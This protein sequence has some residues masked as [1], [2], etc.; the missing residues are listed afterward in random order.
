M[1][2]K[3]TKKYFSLTLVF[4]F[5]LVTLA[6]C[7]SPG[8]SG[9]PPGGSGAPAGGSG[10]TADDSDDTPAA[11]VLRHNLAHIFQ[12]DS[13]Q[14]RGALFFA[15]TL[16]ERTGGVIDIT[17]FP[18]SQLGDSDSQIHGL[19][20]GSLGFA[21]LNQGSSAGVHPLLDFHY[22]PFIALN[23]AQVDVLFYGDGIIPTIMTETLAGLG[24]RV[25]GWYEVEFR[26]LSNSKG[27][28][29]SVADM[30]GLRLRVPGSRAL[31]EFFRACGTQPV[32]MPFAELYT[33]LMQGTMDGQENGISMTYNS[34]LHEVNTYFTPLNHSI[35][36]GSIAISE[37]LWQTLSAELQE[38]IIEVAQEAQI[39]QI[40]ENRNDISD[41]LERMI[42]EGT[43]VTNL[44]PEAMA[45]F[46]EIGH[47]V[48]DDLADAYGAERIATLRAESEAVQ[49]LQ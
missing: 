31:M 9:T 35:A 7:S 30:E 5:I 16:R 49:H 43:T 28:V 8:G 34:R 4:L 22:L 25:L 48:W 39:Y 33:A 17:V 42:A 32:A 47:A 15:D 44:T 18:D 14:H 37:Q 20:D 41:R 21:F 38:I 13:A 10:T 45:E 11:E 1:L 46:R 23:N 24:I 29:H 26:G 40:T 3:G 6:G 12:L 19:A 2:T 36:T 27:P